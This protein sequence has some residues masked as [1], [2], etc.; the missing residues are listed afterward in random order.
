MVGTIY[1]PSLS[2][3]SFLLLIGFKSPDSYSHN[4]FLGR[5][6]ISRHCVCVHASMCD[7][8]HVCVWINFKDLQLLEEKLLSN[9]VITVHCIV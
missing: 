7:G 5:G 8:V 2:F 9:P 6:L 3:L 4:A 1:A